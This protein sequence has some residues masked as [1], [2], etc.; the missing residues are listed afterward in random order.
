MLTTSDIYIC[1]CFCDIYAV[2]ACL[3]VQEIQNGTIL[4]SLYRGQQAETSNALHKLNARLA[5]IDQNLGLSSVTGYFYNRCQTVLYE[6]I[7]VKREAYHGQALRGHACLQVIAYTY[8]HIIH[9]I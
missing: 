8:T 7:K 3:C 5:I 4:L 9:V 6:E 1:S 2:Y